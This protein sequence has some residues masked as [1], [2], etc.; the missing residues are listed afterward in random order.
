MLGPNGALPLHLTEYARDRLRNADDPTMSRFLDVFHH[1]MILF[2]FRAWAAGQPT[3]DGDRGD[4]AAH[5]GAYVGALEGLGLAALRDRDDFPDAAK[6]FYAGRL[7]A[8]GRN[9]EGL[10]AVVGDFFGVPTRVE[11]FVREWLDLPSVSAAGASARGT[12]SAAWGLSARCSAPARR[13]TPE[14]VPRRSSARR[15]RSSSS[16]CCRAATAS[17]G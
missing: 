17:G 11:P 13:D 8:Q 4:A 15:S 1:R 6:L 9:A 16:A 2:M 3:V 10:A 12:A 14:Q 5:F 7:A